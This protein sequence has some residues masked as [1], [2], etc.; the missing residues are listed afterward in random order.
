MFIQLSL[1]AHMK[2]DSVIPLS[3]LPIEVSGTFI[4]LTLAGTVDQILVYGPLLATE[5]L[6]SWELEAIAW[7]LWGGSRP[8]CLGRKASQTPPLSSRAFAVR[9]LAYLPPPLYRHSSMD[10]PCGVAAV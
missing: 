3:P 2:N 5:S 4:L 1:R 9:F 8:W 6:S 7:E 10:E